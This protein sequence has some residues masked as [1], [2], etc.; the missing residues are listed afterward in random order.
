[1]LCSLP[2]YEGYNTIQITYTIPS[3]VQG[4]EHPNPG[5]RY[6]AISRTAYLPSTPEGWEVLKVAIEQPDNYYDN[7]CVIIVVAEGIP[8]Q[9]DIHN[10]HISHYWS[11]E[12]CGVE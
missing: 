1:M 10:R 5:Q 11:P 12:C 2:G 3:G 7:Y 8:G 4:P 6:K 9:D